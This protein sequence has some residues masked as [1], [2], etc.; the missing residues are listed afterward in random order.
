M[1]AVH[2]YDNAI[3]KHELSLQNEKQQLAMA[4]AQHEDF[5]IT[6]HR[7][8]AALEESG[9]KSLKESRDEAAARVRDIEQNCK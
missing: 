7:S 9:I 1:T 2:I 4:E 5:S 6:Q 8:L 3:M